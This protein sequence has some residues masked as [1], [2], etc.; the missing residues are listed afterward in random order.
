MGGTQQFLLD[1]RSTYT[2][3][4]EGLWRLQKA[5]NYSVIKRQDSMRGSISPSN[6]ELT[7]DVS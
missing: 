1:Y 5:L 4:R 2:N 3:R 6:T 7:S